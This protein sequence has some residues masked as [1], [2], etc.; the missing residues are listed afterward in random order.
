MGKSFLV[1][2]FR[3]LWFLENDLFYFL[4]AYLLD[5]ASWFKPVSSDT[6]SVPWPTNSVS[7]LV[8]QDGESS[9]WVPDCPYLFQWAVVWRWTLMRHWTIWSNC[10]NE[11]Q[12]SWSFMWTC[13]H[14]LAEYIA[15]VCNIIWDVCNWHMLRHRVKVLVQL[16]Q[17]WAKLKLLAIFIQK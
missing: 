3:A 1:E 10:F 2:L 17:W 16:G 11:P 8:L 9:K 7:L 13:Y 12:I 6:V 14:L 4:L 15:I 5:T